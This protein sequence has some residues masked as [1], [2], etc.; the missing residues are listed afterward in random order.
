LSDWID[1]EI[2]TGVIIQ[3]S[4]GKAD[5]QNVLRTCAKERLDYL[6]S[7]KNNEKEIEELKEIEKEIEFR[8]GIIHHLQKTINDITRESCKRNISNDTKGTNS[9]TDLVKWQSLSRSDQRF[10]T[11]LIF[12]QLVLSKIEISVLQENVNDITSS[13]ISKAVFEE[14]Q[15]SD[16]KMKAL[17]IS[18]SKDVMAILETTQGAMEQKVQK[19][20][21]GALS[22]GLDNSVQNTIDTM[23]NSYFTGC[24]E[25]SEGVRNELKELK[26]EEN[27]IKQVAENFFL[28]GM[29]KPKK[30]KKIVSRNSLEGSSEE[31]IFDSE[32]L[33]DSIND[34]EDSDWTPTPNHQRKRKKF[35][36]NAGKIPSLGHPEK[37]DVKK[38]HLSVSNE[39]VLNKTKSSKDSSEDVPFPVIK[40][41][42]VDDGRKEYD[43]SEEDVNKMKVAELRE[44][45]RKLGLP[46]SG[47]KH[48]LI[49]RILKLND[50]SNDK[51]NICKTTPPRIS[52]TIRDNSFWQHSVLKNHSSTQ[53]ILSGM[54][55]K[56]K[57]ETCNIGVSIAKRK[58][59]ITASVTEKLEQLDQ[60]VL[61]QK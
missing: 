11:A 26:S 13:A 57:R 61:F 54:N 44:I 29:K 55:D 51:E 16:K 32:D 47:R 1:Q 19:I 23:L 3:T 60:T 48:E 33:E 21:L 37:N 36:S 30:A 9:F 49:Q 46:V 59:H 27:G 41:H 58:K 50:V 56:R 40:N 12:Q 14:K 25:A 43:F 35:T 52:P 5:E 2:N 24:K 39:Y 7:K 42:F 22:Q 53:N 17:K 34:D 28:S 18:H 8:T 15:Q 45:L 10:I 31:D 38:M 20:A 4:K 6:K